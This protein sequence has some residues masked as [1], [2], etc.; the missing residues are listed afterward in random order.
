MIAVLGGSGVRLRR[1]RTSWSPKAQQLAAVR[2]AAGTGAFA[3]RLASAQLGS[4]P[5]PHARAA[6]AARKANSCKPRKRG[7]QLIAHRRLPR[8]RRADRGACEA[9]IGRGDPPTG[10]GGVSVSRAGRHR[11]CHR[12]S[13]LGTL[14]GSDIRPMP[15]NLRAVG[16]LR[17]DGLAD[18]VGADR[19]VVGAPGV[20][21]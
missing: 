21:K 11:S 9:N 19:A 17:A 5:K 6:E 4:A 14:G 16:V 8:P 2:E 10:A 12:G 13:P 3:S 20:P 1:Q 18:A 15:K 7:A